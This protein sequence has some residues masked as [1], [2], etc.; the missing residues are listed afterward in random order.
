M[1]VSEL[2]DVRHAEAEVLRER[3]HF[4]DANMQFA[5]ASVRSVMKVSESLMQPRSSFCHRF[6]D[7]DL[8]QR[9]SI[10][11]GSL[12]APWAEGLSVGG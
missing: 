4:Q 6:R 12:S 10:A 8:G 11:L 1:V 2:A 5:E 3:L 7:G 9:S